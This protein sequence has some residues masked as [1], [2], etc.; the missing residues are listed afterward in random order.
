MV[1]K[2]ADRRSMFDMVMLSSDRA[3]CSCFVSCFSCSMVP[4]ALA[5]AS[6][7]EIIVASLACSSACV[8][9]S[10]ATTPSC[11]PFETTLPVI[12][13]VHECVGV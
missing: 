8:L 13:Q 4:S 3:R 6:V 7:N 2:L 11:F 10:R 12:V 9:A 5:S 1:V